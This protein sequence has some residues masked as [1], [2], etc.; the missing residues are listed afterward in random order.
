MFLKYFL[1]DCYTTINDLATL[2][3]ALV[4][5]WAFLLIYILQYK[6][7][8]QHRCHKCYSWFNNNNIKKP[9]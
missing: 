4:H 5:V 8:T 2:A 7:A 3:Y 6:C 9:T 1:T